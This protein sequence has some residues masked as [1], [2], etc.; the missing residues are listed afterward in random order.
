MVPI[1]LQFTLQSVSGHT[2]YAAIGLQSVSLP[3]AVLT[4]MP[5]NDTVHPA[6]PEITTAYPSCSIVKYTD[7]VSALITLCC[8]AAARASIALL[9]PNMLPI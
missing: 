7:C 2:G 3:A 4:T 6:L 8:A 5:L 1:C 9:P